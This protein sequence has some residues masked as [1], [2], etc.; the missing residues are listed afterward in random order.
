MKLHLTDLTV[1]RLHELG[2]YL[3]E[4]TPGFGIRVGKNRKTWIVVR[5]HIRQRVRIGHYPAMSLAAARKEAKRLL[6]EKPTRNA[7]ITFE[8]AFEGYKESIAN[9]KRL[10]TPPAMPTGSASNW[11]T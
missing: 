7:T 9:R 2:T 10:G 3:D 1:Q 5:G 4:T 6:L 8:K 11:M